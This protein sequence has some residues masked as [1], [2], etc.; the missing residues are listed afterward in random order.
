MV[1]DLYLFARLKR[2]GS[3]DLKHPLIEIDNPTGH[4]R[5]CQIRILPLA[6]EILAG[7][8]SMIELNGLDDWLGGV[9]LTQDN[10]IW[11]EDTMTP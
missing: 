10:F 11:R 7:R 2:F 4:M 1:G 6:H 5:E 3:P 9:H 8:A